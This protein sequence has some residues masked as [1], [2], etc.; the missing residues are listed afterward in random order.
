MDGNVVIINDDMGIDVITET[1]YNGEQIRRAYGS[2]PWPNDQEINSIVPNPGP[3]P[4]PEPE[5]LTF[6]ALE[7]ST[8]AINR[9]ENTYDQNEES[10]LDISY[11]LDGTVWN[12]YNLIKEL[13][14]YQLSYSYDESEEDPIEIDE[15]VSVEDLDGETIEEYM[16]RVYPDYYEKIT[17]DT[18]YAFIGDVIEL[19]SDSSV[20]FKGTNDSLNSYYFKMTGSIEASGDVTSLLNGIGGDVRLNTQNCLNGLFSNCTALKTV[21]NLPSTTLSYYCYYSMFKGCTNLT[22]APEL[23]ATTLVDGCYDYMFCDCTSL[24]YVKCLATNIDTYEHTQT[25]SW[26]S[27]VSETGTFIKRSGV[28]WG[29]GESLIPEGWTV[30]E[31]DIEPGP[32]PEPEPEPEPEPIDPNV[33]KVIL[34]LQNNTVGEKAYVQTFTDYNINPSSLTQDIEGV[35][36]TL[37]EEFS[38]NE[39]NSNYNN[40][41]YCGKLTEVYI[42][43]PNIDK[44][45]INYNYKEYYVKLEEFDGYDGIYVPN[46]S[47]G[48]EVIIN[49]N[50]PTAFMENITISGPLYHNT[51][52]GE[53]EIVADNFVKDTIIITET[54]EEEEIQKQYTV[55]KGTLTTTVDE[56]YDMSIEI[57]KPIDEIKFEKFYGDFDVNLG[58]PESMITIDYYS[59]P[60]GYTPMSMYIFNVW[61]D[62]VGRKLVD[63]FKHMY[64]FGDVWAGDSINLPN[65]D[66][67]EESDKFY[68]MIKRP[69]GFIER[70]DITPSHVFMNYVNPCIPIIYCEDIDYITN[71]ES[72]D[73]YRISL[74]GKPIIIQ[75]TGDMYYDTSYKPGDLYDSE[76]NKLVSS[77][78]WISLGDPG[79]FKANLEHDYLVD[80][81]P[82]SVNI[83]L[84]ENIFDTKIINSYIDEKLYEIPSPVKCYIGSNEPNSTVV[85]DISGYNE[86]RVRYNTV[87]FEKLTAVKLFDNYFTNLVVDNWDNK[88]RVIDSRLFRGNLIESVD[89]GDNY[90]GD[91]SL[92][93]NNSPVSSKLN[94]SNIKFIE[95]EYND[96]SDEPDEPE[97]Y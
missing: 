39:I 26:L 89:I 6:T 69:D 2:F 93:Y 16:E 58:F 31:V 85:V 73:Q 37:V 23:P 92:I 67:F 96:G 4:Q 8:I 77:E 84:N 94:I 24:N 66:Q 15:W 41:T 33:N 30:E 22:S 35:I 87:D 82:V 46:N 91:L 57:T 25:S 42:D 64:V 38:D 14:G 72:E 86:F 80:E 17:V 1:P 40:H 97:S 44:P 90:H 76:H 34:Y 47:I 9:E 13:S 20:K 19:S 10:D 51:W 79:I 75:L 62:M 3:E 71:D 36:Q 61:I 28:N 12:D 68:I 78:N 88:G 52:S 55:F 27:G 74:T 53:K 63:N 11:S 60:E 59:I 95:E 21:P 45:K 43:T 54:D 29:T 18:Y 83:L 65:Y 7:N 5:C 49:L 48:E 50:L 32:D 56:S 81:G 70:L